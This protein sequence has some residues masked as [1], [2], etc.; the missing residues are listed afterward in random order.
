M[1][2]CTNDRTGDA[3]QVAWGM[4]DDKPTAQLIAMFLDAIRQKSLDERRAF[5]AEIHRVIVTLDDVLCDEFNLSRR[6]RGKK[7]RLTN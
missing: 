5:A 3:G 2:A 7:K 6:G 1:P 4:M